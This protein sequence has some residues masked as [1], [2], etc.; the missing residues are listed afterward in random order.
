VYV[1]SVRHN[2][3]WAE[4]LVIRRSALG[5]LREKQGIGSP[6]GEDNLILRLA[7]TAT[8]VRNKGTSSQ[9]Y[10]NA[11]EPWPTPLPFP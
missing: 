5:S 11:W 7:F 10:R 8:D 4:F 9:P 1:F 3:R 6:A 2:D